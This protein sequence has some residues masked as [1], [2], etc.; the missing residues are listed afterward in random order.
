MSPNEKISKSAASECLLSVSSRAKGIR[1]E[2]TA[3]FQKKVFKNSNSS[4]TY[5]ENP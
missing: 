1:D 3:I 2:D 5:S 4:H